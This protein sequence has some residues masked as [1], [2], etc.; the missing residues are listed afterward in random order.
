MTY[1]SVWNLTSSPPAAKNERDKKA[2]RGS[3]GL[4]VEGNARPVE[5]DSLVLMEHSEDD[6][7]MVLVDSAD[8]EEGAEPVERPVPLSFVIRRE[9][10]LLDLQ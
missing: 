3:C 8:R 6:Y 9:L 4:E 2:E 1:V 5:L 10:A 7:D